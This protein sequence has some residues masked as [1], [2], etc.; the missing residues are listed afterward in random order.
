[1]RK[2]TINCHFTK[3]P[4]IT[5]GYIILYPSLSLYWGNPPSILRCWRDAA[6]MDFAPKP[7]AFA[8]RPAA[9]PDQSSSLDCVA[10]RAKR[11]PFL[12]A[13]PG[14]RSGARAVEIVLRDQSSGKL[15]NITTENG[16]PKSSM[17]KGFSILNYPALGVP[18]L[19]KT[20]K[21]EGGSWPADLGISTKHPTNQPA[22][23][24]W[25]LW[26]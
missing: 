26:V 6:A 23:Y 14:R 4:S 17:F 10:S 25:V 1:M 24:I 21:I 13:D 2:S 5:R 9:L 12:G 11:R 20:P 15:I 7:L 18:H 22:R 19:W 16:V 3:P 8:Y